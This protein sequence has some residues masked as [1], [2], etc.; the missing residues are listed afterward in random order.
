MS[1]TRDQAG[2]GPAAGQVH[3]TGHGLK[4]NLHVWEAIGLSVGAMSPAL[5]MSFS[6]PGVA[7][8][9]GRGAALSFVFAG[10]TCCLIGY[11][12]MLLTRKYNHAGSVYGFVG[13][14]LGPRLGVFSGWAMSLM[15][16][17]FVPAS[18]AASGYF[19]AGVLQNLGW[20]KG[21]DWIWLALPITVIIWGFC[22]GVIKRS[23]RALLYIEA[24]T[25]TLIVALMVI[26]VVKVG[27]GHGLNGGTLTG[28]IFTLPSGVNVHALILGSVFG[29]LAFAGFE[30]AG[31]LGEEAENPRQAI[32]KAIG[33]S[34]I[35]LAVFYVACIAVQSLGFGAT[36]KGSTAFAG[37]GGPLFQLADVYVGGTMRNLIELGAAFSAFGAGLGAAVA[38]ARLIYAISRDGAP[39]IPLARVSQ[40]SGSPRPAVLLVIVINVI[41]LVILRALG[42]TGLQVWQY[43]GTLGTLAILVGYGMVNIGATRAVADR[44]LGVPR[45]RGVL[46]A[47]AV[48]LVGYVLYANIYPAPAFPYNLFPYILLAWLVIGAA[49]I[50]LS[51]KLARR[52]GAGLAQDLDLPEGRVAAEALAYPRDG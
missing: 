6:G 11:G 47:I 12:Y 41:C 50:A 15:Y 20:W 3:I 29:F 21:A 48:I 8:L 9:V 44:S 10:V 45:W 30:G 17:V 46:P 18:A 7:A 4:R 25:V 33:S 35:A 43:L 32:P 49:V 38:G 26:I 14:S 40:P 19:L 42:A 51:P 34:V 2:P 28:N 16:F 36:A 24:V 52:A 31:A 27:Q 1:D 37:S 23:T 22:A 39:S 5:A 13:A